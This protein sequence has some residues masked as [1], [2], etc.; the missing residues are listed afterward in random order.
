VQA[1]AQLGTSQAAITTQPAFWPSGTAAGACRSAT[2]NHQYL[3][4]L[5]TTLANAVDTARDQ[6]RDIVL[7]E[8]SVKP[9]EPARSFPCGR[10]SAG[11]P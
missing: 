10:P 8:L 11:H 6:H 5:I 2:I 7:A 3:V 4:A 1:R 9:I